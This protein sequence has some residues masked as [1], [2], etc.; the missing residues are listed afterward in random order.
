MDEDYDAF[1]AER[2]GTIRQKMRDF[3]NEAD[4]THFVEKLPRMAE[5]I[6]PIGEI[7]DSRET[8]PDD[9]TNGDG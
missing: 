7:E 4:L 2:A 3:V 9:E 8:E 5:D 1:L 6:I